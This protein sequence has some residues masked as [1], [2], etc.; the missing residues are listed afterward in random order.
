MQKIKPQKGCSVYKLKLNFLVESVFDFNKLSLRVLKTLKK[1]QNEIK[2]KNKEKAIKEFIL[3]R[4]SHQ[5]I[6]S[7][8]L[9]K[10]CKKLLIGKSKLYLQKAS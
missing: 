8:F 2:S 5:L 9:T 1:L 7:F 3:S 4:N 10:F 6:I